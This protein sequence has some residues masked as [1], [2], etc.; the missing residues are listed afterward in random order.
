MDDLQGPRRVLGARG[1]EH[2]EKMQDDY[3]K[4]LVKIETLLT[5]D[6]V[7]MI[8]YFITD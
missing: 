5:F 6:A 8:G 4:E 7:D 2:E 1:P 3:K